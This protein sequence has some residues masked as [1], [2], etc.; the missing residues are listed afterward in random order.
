MGEA[1]GAV[2]KGLKSDVMAKL[3]ECQFAELMTHHQPRGQTDKCCV[4]C[5]EFELQETVKLLK[6]CDHVSCINSKLKHLATVRR[7]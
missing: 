5:C 6:P 4:C 1:V 2:S 7:L 3:P